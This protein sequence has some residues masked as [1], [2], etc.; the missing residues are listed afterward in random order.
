MSENN[1]APRTSDAAQSDERTT[2]SRS[3]LD[4]LATFTMRILRVPKTAIERPSPPT[5]G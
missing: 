3:S 1:E 5:S 2:D 4:R